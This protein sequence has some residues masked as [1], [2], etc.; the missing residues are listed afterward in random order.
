M[1]AE[2]HRNDRW[3]S[4][5]LFTLTFVTGLIDAVSF[6][7][8]DHVFVANMTGNVVFLAFGIVDTREFSIAASSLALIGFLAGAVA[9]GKL[10]SSY[11]LDR[12]QN[13]ALALGINMLILGAAAAG[14]AVFPDATDARIHYALIAQLAFAMG[15]QNATARRLAVPDLTTTVVT[16]TLT[17][18]AADSR[19]AGG[20]NLRPLRRI[21]AVAIMFAG[22]LVGATLV[23]QFNTAA[24]IGLAFL[25]VGGLTAAAFRFQ[26]SNEPWRPHSQVLPIAIR[27]PRQINQASQGA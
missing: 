26:R 21:A 6:F 18:L 27:D 7:R 3:L 1:T 17:G 22:A 13:L 2:A 10:G 15:L 23:L 11:R 12:W 19:W 16:M 25:I 14:T 20:G 24:A 8:L 9:G 4:A 5:L